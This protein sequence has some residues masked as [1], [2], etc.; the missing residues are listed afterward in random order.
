MLLPHLHRTG[1]SSNQSLRFMVSNSMGNLS[2]TKHS[3]PLTSSKFVNIVGTFDGSTVN[4]YKDGVLFGTSKFVGNYSSNQEL[5]LHVGS[6]AY[7]SSCNRWAGIIDD[8]RLYNRTLAGNEVKEIALS[9][10]ADSSLD[11]LIFHLTFDDNIRDSSGK[12]NHGRMF[13]PIGS[14]AYTPDD[15]L[16]FTEKNTGLIRVMK[17]N[18]VLQK[19]FAIIS[20]NYVNW[21]QGLLGLTIDPDFV[22]NHFIYLYYTSVGNNNN[23]GSGNPFNR[24]VRF[25]EKNNTATEMVVLLDNIPAS[26]GFHS[27]GGLA[28]G[29]DDKLYITVG[30]ATEA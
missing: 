30:D 29:P 6:A 3:V 16:F 12:N 26:Q 15:R 8:L 17:D 21:E 10:T 5:P 4:V 28:F 27:G 25:T 1:E 18:K 7:C 22:K 24:V 23:E 13:T 2:G 19:P 9:N 14:M 20:D 11:D